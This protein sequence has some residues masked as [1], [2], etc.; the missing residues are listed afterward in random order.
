MSF[1][2]QYYLINIFLKHL[3]I[4]VT[5]GVPQQIFLNCC[6]WWWYLARRQVSYRDL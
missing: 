5:L 3:I 4:V 1:W 2:I 6:Y